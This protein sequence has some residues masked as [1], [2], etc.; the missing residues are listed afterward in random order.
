MPNYLHKAGG[1]L[2]GGFPW[3]IGMISTSSA[4]E[5]AA[6]TSWSDAIQAMWAVGDFIDLVPAGTLLTYTSTSTASADFKQTTL[7][8]TTLD[9]AGNATA[10]LPYQVAEVVTWRTG[11][12]TKWGRGRWYL[13]PLSPTALVTAGFVLSSTSAGYVVAGVN[14]AISSWSGTLNPQILHRKATLS[15][16]AA[17]TL[18]PIS[19]GDVSEKLVIQKRRGDK[20]V[21]TRHDLTF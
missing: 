13:P 1:T 9:L 5:A 21:P 10:G 2:E 17:N 12:A 14:A 11:Y 19:G 18:T 7:T 3:S 15:G 8:E 6:E 16:P 20:Y 4:S